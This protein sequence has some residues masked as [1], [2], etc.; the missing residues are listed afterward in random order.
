MPTIPGCSA[1][2]SAPDL[3]SGCRVFESPHP[4][5]A[6]TGMFASC[7]CLNWSL[8]IG[9]CESSLHKSQK[10]YAIQNSTSD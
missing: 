6:G 5:L 2:G 8:Y 1:V 4:E 9:H 3:G 7:K 10:V